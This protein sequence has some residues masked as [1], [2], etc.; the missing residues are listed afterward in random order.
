MDKIISNIEN[1][2]NQFKEHFLTFF[3]QTLNNINYYDSDGNTFIIKT[4]SRCN[5]PPYL[6]GP[7]FVHMLGAILCLSFSAV[8]HLFDAYSEKLQS[9]LTRLDYGGISLLI[10]GSTFPPVIYGFACNPITKYTYITVISIACAASF[11]F[12]LLPGTDSPNCRK[13]R[14]LLFVFVG[15]L[16]GAP[17]IQGA[18]STDPNVILNTQYWLGGGLIYLLGALMYIARI[19]ERFAPGKFDF[20]VFFIP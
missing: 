14:G 9:F 17:V 16:A 12:T 2:P 6:L 4:I 20:F 1:I 19:P 13:F 7:L 18:A 8:L 11:I 5:F 10:A 15:L 3:N